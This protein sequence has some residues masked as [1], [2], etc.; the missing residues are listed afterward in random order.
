MSEK[1]ILTRNEFLKYAGIITGGV[2]FSASLLSQVFALSDKAVK[3]LERGQGLESRVNTTCRMCPGG[4]GLTVRRIDGIPISLKGN[5]VSAINRGGL[6]PAAHANLELLYHPDRFTEP[7]TRPEGRLKKTLNPTTWDDSLSSL[8]AQIHQLTTS[9]KGHRIAIINGDSSPL[10]KHCWQEFA[11]QIGTPNFYQENESGLTD[12]SSYATQGIRQLPMLDLVNSE[13]IISLGSNF[14]EEDGSPIHFNQVLGI[15]KDVANVTRNKLIYVGPRAN[16]TANSAHKWI[17]INPDTWGTLALGI[18]HILI[19]ENAI[20]TGFLKSNS[21]GYFDETDTDGKKQ[22]RFETQVRTIFHPK[23]VEE[24]TGV[25]VKEIRYLAGLLSTRQRSVVLCGREA[26][27]TPKGDLHQ[28]AVHCL[29]FI[30]GNVQTPGGWYFRNPPKG[31]SRQSDPLIDSNTA[32]LFKTD[33]THPL[34]APSI[35]MFAKRVEGYA[36]YKTELLI[37]H[38]ANPCYHAENRAKWRATLKHIS[39]VVYLGDLPNETSQYADVILPTHSDLESWD[40]VE[41]IPGIPFDSLSIQKPVI[42]PMYNTLSGFEI[43][44]KVSEEIGISLNLNDTIDKPHDFVKSRIES[45][46]DNKRGK[47]FEE[48][49]HSEWETIYKNHNKLTHTLSKKQFLKTV[50]AN[51]GWWDPA[52]PERL[53]LKDIIRTPSGKFE[54]LPEVLTRFEGYEGDPSQLLKNLLAE[55]KY[56]SSLIQYET[57]GRDEFPLTLIS[58]FPITNPFGKTVYSPTMLE[59]IGIRNEIYWE[60]WV[61]IHPETA[62]HWGVNN[63][64]EIQLVSHVGKEIRVKARVKPIVHPDVVFVPLGLGRIDVGRYGTEVGSDPRELMVPQPEIST[65]RTIVSGTPVRITTL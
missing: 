59:T 57:S 2:G 10:M 49:S 22:I 11:H 14:L 65:G 56:P 13:Y 50:E 61:E 25:P 55:K 32:N 28:W 7:L 47:P 4:C 15:F 27:Q 54:M 18:A 29:N 24:I 23:H 64:D 9:K 58:A 33:E 37:I 38:K 40:I 41:N 34:E 62:R 6:C 63:G 17:P 8:S 60:S 51:G 30:T 21:T 36:P 52:G 35:D 19:E 46:Y 53:R 3:T 42:K 48:I 39:R 43:I 16:I 5:P 44:K 20:D 26:L 1:K 31:S 12:N 45:I